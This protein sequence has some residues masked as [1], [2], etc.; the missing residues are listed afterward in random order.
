MG[1]PGK[2]EGTIFSPV[3]CEI[4]LN[5][6]E[7]VGGERGDDLNQDELLIVTH[8]GPLGKRNLISWHQSF[9]P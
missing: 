2:T 8:F 4:T 6:P 5:G 9:W 3:P 7:R 1:V